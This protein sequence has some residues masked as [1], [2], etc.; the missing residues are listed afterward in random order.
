MTTWTPLITADAFTG[1]RTDLLTSTA[2]LLSLI[3]IVAGIGILIR[4]FR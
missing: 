2:G 1:I 3:L 4:V